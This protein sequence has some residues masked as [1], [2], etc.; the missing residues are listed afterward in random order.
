MYITSRHTQHCAIVL[1]PAS[2]NGVLV[3]FTRRT[4]LNTSNRRV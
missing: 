4:L 2:V 3:K 1:I